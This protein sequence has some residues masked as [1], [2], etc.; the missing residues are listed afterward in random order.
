[1]APRKLGDAD[2][3][4]YGVR[5]ITGSYLLDLPRRRLMRFPVAPTSASTALTWTFDI[6]GSWLP[7]VRLIECTLGAPM[8]ATVRLADVDQPLRT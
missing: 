6:H 7:L 1:M 4:R 8:R 2:V 5:T 3:G